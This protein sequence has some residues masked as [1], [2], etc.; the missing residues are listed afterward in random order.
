MLGDECLID[1]TFQASEKFKLASSLEQFA[2]APMEELFLIRNL[3]SV[4]RRQ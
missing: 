3:L 1:C 2:H 4:Y